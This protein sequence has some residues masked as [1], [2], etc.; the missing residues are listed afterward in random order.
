MGFW[1]GIMEKKSFFIFYLP[2]I[3]M[4]LS[5]CG[6]GE[7][8]PQSTLAPANTAKIT[9]TLLSQDTGQPLASLPE[10]KL[11]CAKVSGGS[12]SPQFVFVPSFDITSGKVVITMTLAGN[13]IK[14]YEGCFITTVGCA[15][16]SANG[17]DEA[18]NLRQIGSVQAG[19]TV[20]LGELKLAYC[21]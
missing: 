16:A 7:V 14:G 20:E 17:A 2:V 1:M 21:R 4:I 13:D 18:V 15:P 19:Q 12:G 9:A 8:I 5:A 3:G 6:S 11:A 10:L